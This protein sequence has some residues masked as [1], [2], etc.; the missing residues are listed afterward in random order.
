MKFEEIEEIWEDIERLN[1]Q[2]SSSITNLYSSPSEKWSVIVFEE[3]YIWKLPKKYRCQ[4]S[5]DINSG[6][7]KFRKSNTLISLYTAPYWSGAVF[8]FPNGNT[9]TL[10]EDTDTKKFALFKCEKI[11]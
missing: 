5:N 11:K 1:A 7:L 6:F 10:P 9:F 4:R 3:G 8:T 2:N